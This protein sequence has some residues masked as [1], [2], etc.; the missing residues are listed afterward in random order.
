LTRRPASLAGIQVLD[1]PNAILVLQI[2][3]QKLPDLF[4]AQTGHLSFSTSTVLKGVA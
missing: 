3:S 2:P 1:Q 4:C